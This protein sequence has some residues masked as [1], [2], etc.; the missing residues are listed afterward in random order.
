MVVGARTGVV[1]ANQK[2]N[3]GAGGPAL[4]H[5]RQDFDPIGLISLGGESALAGTTSVEIVLEV[6]LSEGEPWWAAVDHHA[7]AGAVALA[8][9]GEAEQGSEGAAH[10]T[11]A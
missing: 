8:P 11:R 3:G 9:G 1:V 5:P 4:E 7:D 2:G 6:L 10:G